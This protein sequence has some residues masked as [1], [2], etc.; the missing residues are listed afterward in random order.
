MTFRKRLD[1]LERALGGSVGAK[2]LSDEELVERAR[3]L[4]GRLLDQC[5][6]AGSP[7]DPE[8]L[9]LLERGL[10][11]CPDLLEALSARERE[12]LGLA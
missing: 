7:P 4:T 1:R 5:L 10:S 11:L 8:D 12:H 2:N 9:R 3:A 6:G